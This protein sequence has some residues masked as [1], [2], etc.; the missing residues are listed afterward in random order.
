MSLHKPT[1]LQE[2]LELVSQAKLFRVETS[3][4]ALKVSHSG[5]DR[6]YVETNMACWIAFITNNFEVYDNKPAVLVEL[7]GDTAWLRRG[8]PPLRGAAKQSARERGGW[9]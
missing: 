9:E 5:A 8:R 1:T 6:R 3:L 7:S 2:A 4:P